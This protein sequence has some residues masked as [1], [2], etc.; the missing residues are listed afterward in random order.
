MKSSTTNAVEQ[1]PF[2]ASH[3]LSG[4]PERI[5]EPTNSNSG[6]DFF[7]FPNSNPFMSPS[8]TGVSNPFLSS[9]GVMQ[10]GSSGGGGAGGQLSNPFGLS[11]P[12]FTRERRLSSIFDLEN[13]RDSDMMLDRN[14][15]LSA[16]SFGGAGNLA[17]GENSN[18]SLMGSS[19]VSK[20]QL[21]TQQQQITSFDQA[22][23]L[24]NTSKSG[25]GMNNSTSYVDPFPSEH[26]LFSSCSF[27][28]NA[29]KGGLL[30]SPTPA[31][32][33]TTANSTGMTSF[34]QAAVD[35]RQQQGVVLSSGGIGTSLLEEAEFS[36]SSSSFPSP[37]QFGTSTRKGTSSVPPP[38]NMMPLSMT[39]STQ[40]SATG[41]KQTQQQ[42]Q[43]YTLLQEGQS[44]SPLPPGSTS[45]AQQQQQNMQNLFFQYMSNQSAAAAAA[46]QQASGVPQGTAGNIAGGSTTGAPSGGITHQPFIW[47]SA[48]YPQSATGGDAN[49]QQ[50]GPSSQPPGAFT[51]Q[52]QVQMMNQQMLQQ[53]NASGGNSTTDFLNHP[54][55]AGA[56]IQNYQLLNPSAVSY[57]QH[58]Q[59]YSSGSST[60][61]F[62]DAATLLSQQHQQGGIYKG[63]STP[64]QINTTPS[65]LSQTQRSILGSSSL[66]G[67]SIGT[68]STP[69]PQL[70]QS[71]SPQDQSAS[72][73]GRKR[74]KQ[75]GTTTTTTTPQQKSTSR[76]SKN[77]TNESVSSQNVVATTSG[78]GGGGGAP[79]EAK[80]RRKNVV[81]H[82]TESELSNHGILS[83]GV[84]EE[85]SRE[86]IYS[87]EMQGSS[88][89]PSSLESGGMD[90]QHAFDHSQQGLME[91]DDSN[92][93]N[94][95]K[96]FC[97]RNLIVEKSSQKM[98][99][100]NSDIKEEGTNQ[101]AW[102]EREHQAF[103]KGLQELGYGKWREIADRY[104]KTRTRIQV[105]S[106]SQK[107]HQRLERQARKKKKQQQAKSGKKN[108][109]G[110][111][112]EG[113]S[114][115]TH[116]NQ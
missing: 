93:A 100:V 34:V 97:F 13:S 16:F 72:S 95:Q 26:S 83:S 31:G 114:S 57:R 35:K 44:F 87:K 109:D 28:M 32:E 6:F 63:T 115:S 60:T 98:K 102:S 18:Q 91:E 107:Y 70:A 82:S 46:T 86:L 80:K 10:S 99:F 73:S 11:S 61:G 22:I 94:G 79:R 77:K 108:G 68:P 88:L 56:F 64:L 23:P 8:D 110:V 62:M 43:Q 2:H 53:A 49:Q 25:T 5:E 50:M 3:S 51:F 105:A 75:Q 104:V 37:P 21:L 113:A 27:S 9:S 96:K 38:P 89:N 66:P 103:L 1:L 40:P 29:S 78:G 67:I 90:S 58:A 39:S 12:N 15:S 20:S 42:Q 101:G 85:N 4:A 48:L 45:N 36:K 71:S 19:K 92:D 7:S 106:H 69:S 24:L 17:T 47:T 14:K 84:G 76:S 81:G 55:T 112:E 30:S 41:S 65:A 33:Q 111:D 52:D 116:L 74:K 54:S 59:T